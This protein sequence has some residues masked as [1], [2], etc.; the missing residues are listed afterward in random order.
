MRAS[1]DNCVPMNSEDT[2]RRMQLGILADIHGNSRALEAVLEDARRRGIQQFVDLG[3]VLYGPMEPRRT[4]EL[5]QT[6]ELLAGVSGN[7]DR[8][9]RDA[10][11][12]VRA[13]N[14]T[15]DFV[16]QVL[17]A[18]PIDWLRTLPQTAVLADEILLCHGSPSSDTAYL[19]EDVSSGRPLVR[20]EAEIVSDLGGALNWP[21][22]LCGHTHVPR[23]VQLKNGPLI[24]NPGSVGLPAYDDDAPAPHFMETFSP[25]ASYAVLEKTQA[26][27]A[28]SFH[29][30]PYDWHAAAARARELGRPDW[31][32][33]IEFG[34]ME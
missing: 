5:M 12:V 32:Q 26:G 27:W 13:R 20:P 31:A 23:L 28:A 3:D 30:I 24:L 6:I 17:G 8:F 4:Y 7:Q 25:H 19:L 22:I 33:G 21:V 14:P 11:A 1:T 29:R 9:V 34:R 18:E 2:G 15:V 10:D 16:V